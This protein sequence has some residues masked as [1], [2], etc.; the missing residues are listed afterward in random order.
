MIPIW[1]INCYIF[2]HSVSHIHAAFQWKIMDY[3]VFHRY[4][5]LENISPHHSLDSTLH[6]WKRHE[7]IKYPISDLR[8]CKIKIKLPNIGRNGSC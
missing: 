2:I 5:Y 4:I 3:V 1:E 8:I 7:V 6:Q